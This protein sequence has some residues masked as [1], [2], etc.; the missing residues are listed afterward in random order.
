M[1]VKRESNF[2]AMG[3]L[4]LPIQHVPSLGCR[5]IDLLYNIR[6]HKSVPS[7]LQQN[8]PTP[9][10][11]RTTVTQVLAHRPHPAGP[12]RAPPPRHAAPLPVTWISSL[13]SSSMFLCVVSCSCFCSVFI[14][15]L[16]LTLNFLLSR[17]QGTRSL[18]V[19]R[20]ATEVLVWAL[21][22]C[23]APAP[24][25]RPPGSTGSPAPGAS[26]SATN[27]DVCMPGNL[28]PQT[29]SS[30]VKSGHLDPRVR[31]FRVCHLRRRTCQM[32][33]PKTQESPGETSRVTKWQQRATPSSGRRARP[34]SC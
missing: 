6:R 15:T 14:G 5:P 2:A 11:H 34:I 13:R 28:L 1:C 20:Q 4:A 9:S 7:A 22:Q 10:A 3:A 33:S 26:R 27:S 29:L 19:C 21:P 8:G 31:T 23:S 32:I 12:D 16:M 18:R 17:K 25:H 30:K 24:P